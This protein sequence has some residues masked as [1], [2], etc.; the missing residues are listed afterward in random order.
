MV[1][2]YHFILYNERRVEEKKKGFC[3]A[4]EKRKL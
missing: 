1:A 2:H 3:P 4:G